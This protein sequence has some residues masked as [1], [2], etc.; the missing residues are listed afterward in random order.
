MHMSCIDHILSMLKGD[1]VMRILVT[2][3]RMNEFVRNN[4]DR[5]TDQEQTCNKTFTLSDHL[6]NLKCKVKE[7]LQTD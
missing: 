5:K 3:Q 7:S 1:T 2:V 6:M 4:E